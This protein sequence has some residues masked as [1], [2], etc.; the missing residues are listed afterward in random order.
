M[1]P[2]ELEQRIATL[3]ELV[4]PDDTTDYSTWFDAEKL[5][6]FRWMVGRLVGRMQ[7]TDFNTPLNAAQSKL[8]VI[9]E[10]FDTATQTI[11]AVVDDVN[12]KLFDIQT[13]MDNAFT[14][15]TDLMITKQVA[16]L[17]EGVVEPEE[18]E[19]DET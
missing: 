2:E 12:Q 19:T 14:A 1:T 16:E 5:Q 17:P 15:L 13:D 4:P 3:K 8:V 18:E 11:Q 10:M 7:N 9:R 6:L